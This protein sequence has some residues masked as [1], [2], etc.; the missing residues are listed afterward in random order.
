MLDALRREQSSRKGQNVSKPESPNEAADM[1]KAGLTLVK[2]I[3]ASSS[4]RSTSRLCFLLHVFKH[5][6]LQLI[7]KC[8]HA[9]EA[10][11]AICP[12]FGLL[13]QMPSEGQ[14]SILI[15]LTLSDYVHL[16]TDCPAED[17][18]YV[19]ATPGLEGSGVL[20]KK[21]SSSRS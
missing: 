18:I 16:S 11:L 3:P 20:Y 4:R 17:S 19:V 8:N 12:S 13:Q 6:A 7:Q 9:W 21:I 1:A 5:L 10:W 2:C 14:Q 15:A